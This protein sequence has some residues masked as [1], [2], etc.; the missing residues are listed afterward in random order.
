MIELEYDPSNPSPTKQ[1]YL[2]LEYGK[3]SNNER[4]MID[5]DSK[6]DQ[7]IFWFR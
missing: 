5:V 3:L 1:P 6:I 2:V 7:Y 4:L